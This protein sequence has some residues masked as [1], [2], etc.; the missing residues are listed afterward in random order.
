MA[1]TL[2]PL[3]L[4]FLETLAG[5]ARPYDEVAAAWR[6]SCPRLT[7][8]EDALDSGYVARR[9]PGGEGWIVELTP[10]GRAFLHRHGREPAATRAQ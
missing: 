8:W 6:T 5:R 2:E 1:A 10:A 3:I 9:A 4:D 7:V